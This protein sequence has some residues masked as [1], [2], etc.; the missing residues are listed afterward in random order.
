VAVTTGRAGSAGLGQTV[1]GMIRTR[2]D[3]HRR[4]AASSHG[5]QMHE[6]VG[7]LRHAAAEGHTGLLPIVEKAVAAAMRVVLRADD[8]S[9]IIGD[10]IRDLLALHA[11]LARR[12]PPGASKLVTWLAKFQFDGTQD[13]FHIDIADYAPALGAK[14]VALYRAQLAEI[15]AALGPAPTE[16]QERAYFE[17]RFDDPDGWRRLADTRHTRFL[18][19]YNAQRLAVV[20]RD[21]AAV[22]ATH[23]RDGKAV[24]LHD[25]AKA[26]AE[27]DEF[28]LAIDF[29]RRAADVDRGWQARDAAVWWCDLLAA[30]RPEEEA[31]A[32]LEVFRRWPS[33]STA[34]QLRRAAG[35]TW[36]VHRD[37]VLSTLAA[38]PRD[39][40]VFAQH[41]L[42]D[43]ELAWTLAH[44]L[45][46]T[47]GRTWSGL[48]D[49]YEKVNPMEV[50]PV[51]RRLVLGSLAEADARSYQHVARLLRRMRRIAAGTEHAAGVD[52]LIACLREKHRRRPRLQR[53]FDA[54][55]LP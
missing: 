29:A 36:P 12:T 4:S 19:T 33:S 15:E 42:H 43:I 16:E 47:D 23:V 40:V 5:R 37:A 39:A 20:D 6:A 45:V 21:V 32:R 8:S 50:L 3:L 30:H 28:D 51:L 46:L 49:A 7:L 18:L 44:N 11:D 1:L 14:G 26:L 35:N 27:I 55:K 17:R 2:A 41:H 10:A 34:E 53:E 31:A 48:A 13:F 38:S 9:G 25:T 22:I 24:W 54:A 52:D